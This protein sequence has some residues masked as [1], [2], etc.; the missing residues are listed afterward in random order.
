MKLRIRQKLILLMSLSLVAT[1]GMA[2]SAWWQLQQVTDSATRMTE[3]RLQ[4]VWRLN[5]IARLYTQQVVDVAHKSRSQMLFW[6]EADKLVDEAVDEIARQWQAYREGALTEPE[7]LILEENRQ[8]FNTAEAAIGKLKGYI[9]EQSSYGMGSFVDLELYAGIE[10]ILALVDQLVQEQGRLAEQAQVQ[11]RETARRAAVMLI[12]WVVVLASVVGVVGAWLYHSIIRPIRR[13]RDRVLA[14]EQQRDFTLRTNLP[15]GDELGDLSQAFDS[16]VDRQAGMLRRLQEM[17][18]GL[19]SAADTLV[20]VAANT[21]AKAAEQSREI[22]VMVDDLGQVNNAAERVLS[23]V[24]DTAHATREAGEV[25]QQGN[26][27]V[28]ETIEAINGLA[29]RVAESVSSMNALIGHSEQIG[30]VL[31]VIKSIAEQTNLLAL[32]AAIEAARAGEQGRG[33]AVVA[34]EVRQLASRTASSTQ[35]I[36]AII[37]NIQQG[38]QRAAEQMQAGE[39]A[40]SESVH[41]AGRAEQALQKIVTAFD[42]IH[43]HSNTI[44]RASGEQLQVTGAVNDRVRRVTLIADDTA[45]MSLTAANSSQQVAD[46]A[47]SIRDILVAYRT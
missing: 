39:A 33:F 30:S 19:S 6:S 3:E 16:L 20:A 34:D 8:A 37:E 10:P 4:P 27:T 29:S 17:G 41:T 28:S 22:S 5:R 24:E 40:A 14:V 9:A 18:Q 25:A 12:I 11:A 32:N 44:S 42:D 46:L 7:Q 43:G 15:P 35:E 38:T 13:V 2:L 31:A 36:Q 47:E 1:A 23:S 21:Q 45:D 26:T